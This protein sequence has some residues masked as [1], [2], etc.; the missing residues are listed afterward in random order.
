[1]EVQ[2]R[3]VVV[4]LCKIDRRNASFVK[5]SEKSSISQNLGEICSHIKR[6]FNYKT[7]KII[8]SELMAHDII[9]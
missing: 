5:S 2:L 6:L 9:A 8:I 4:L 3:K 1:M 7:C